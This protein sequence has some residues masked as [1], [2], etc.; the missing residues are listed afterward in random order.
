MLP[1]LPNICAFLEVADSGR[2]RLAA[3]RLGVSES[4][5]SHQI[6][7]LEEQL[8]VR[9][10]ERGRAE[11]TLT[12]QGELYYVK[13]REAVRLL[14]EAAED[15]GIDETSRLSV[16][17]PRSLAAL[18]LV[19]QLEAF[20]RDNP[21]C[22]VQLLPTE[23]VCDLAREHIDIGIRQREGAQAADDWPGCRVLPLTTERIFPVARPDVAARAEALGWEV[24]LESES[25][26]LND[27]HPGEWGAWSAAQGLPAPA[28]Q[29]MKALNS[30]DFVLNA[31]L[32][33]M[34]IAMA[35]TPMVD[36]V[37]AEG[38]LVP[39]FG[40]APL[41]TAR[42]DLVLPEDLPLR[43]LRGRF[44]RWLQTLAGSEA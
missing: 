13:A 33:G 35:R 10:L 24:A 44:A 2:F 15:L 36:A 39:V 17:L 1:P 37:L 34:G 7:R 4:A 14:R 12:R 6:R 40:G 42:Y 8:G 19:P 32:S 3:E 28:R 43:G 16:T 27:L 21:G 29:R 41:E 30:F 25:F 18:W 26:I 31:A 9:L 23:R 11:A 38:R 5:V 22:E 20:Y